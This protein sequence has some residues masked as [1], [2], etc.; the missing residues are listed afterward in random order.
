LR[1]D[2]SVTAHSWEVTPAEARDI[3]Q[4]LRRLVVREDDLGAVRYVAGT[5]VAFEDGLNT[6]RGAVAVLSFPDLVLEEHAI[7][8]RPT[9]FPYVPGLL[10]FREI[11]VL[12]EAMGRLQRAP[13][14]VLCDGQGY[15]HPRRF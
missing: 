14:I 3:Q 5:D 11:P 15:A 8:R 13:D 12:L 1:P 7:A 4:D 6:T 9:T 2:A 10:S